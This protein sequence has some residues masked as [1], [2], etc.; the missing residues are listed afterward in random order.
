QQYVAFFS[1]AGETGAVS[2]NWAY[3]GTDIVN[4]ADGYSGGNFVFNNSQEFVGGWEDPTFYGG[5]TSHDLAFRL[6][7]AAVPEP[8]TVTMVGL[9]ITAA[10]L[11]GFGRYRRAKRR[12]FSR[13]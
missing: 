1:T 2:A 5:Q 10:G 6:S 3:L 4:G 13:R 12:Q 11:V 8:T 7:F 9:G